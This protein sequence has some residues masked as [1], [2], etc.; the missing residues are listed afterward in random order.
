MGRVAIETG[1][2]TR[3]L[4][5]LSSL[6][7]PFR[8]AVR[9]HVNESVDDVVDNVSNYS[10]TEHALNTTFSLGVIT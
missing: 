5:L 4:E 2:R 8:N 3:Q 6:L 10:F 9:R 1:R 7:L